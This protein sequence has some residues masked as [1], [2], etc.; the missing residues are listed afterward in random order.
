MPAKSW[1]REFGMEWI[2]LRGMW[3]KNIVN[4]DEKE[5][6]E[7]QRMLEQYKLRV[8]DIA[9]PLFKVDWPG[10]PKSKFSPKAA[11]I[12]RGFHVRSAGRSPRPVA[13]DSRRLSARARALLRFLAAR[14]S[15][16]VSRSHESEIAGRRGK[17]GDQ[18]DSR[19]RKRSLLQHWHGRGS[20]EGARGGAVSHLMVNWDPGNAAT[21]RDAV[22]RWL[23]SAA[24]KSHRPLPLQGRGEEGQGLRLGRRGRWLHR[25]D[26]HSSRSLRDGYHYAVSLETHWRGAGTPEEST[27]QEL[28]RNERSIAKGGRAL[29]RLR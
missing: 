20:S 19:A 24:E 10:A 4:L 1:P 9:S 7:A 25:L 18:G 28:G 23:Q 2:E 17:A 13:R 3:N 6:A 22:S 27:R 5:V 11:A 21:R 26:G 8:S 29:R 16:A 14:R 12:R 15:G